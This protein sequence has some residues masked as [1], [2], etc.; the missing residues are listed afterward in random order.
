MKEGKAFWKGKL[1]G[2]YAGLTNTADKII[3]E[4]PDINKYKLYVEPF[5]GKGRTARFIDIPMILNDRSEYSVW[6]CK[7]EF[8]NASVS[9]MDFMDTIDKYDDHDVFFLLDP[10]WRKKHYKESDMSFCDR[11]V[12]DYYKQLLDRVETMKGDWFLCGSADEHESNNIIRKS[13][14]GLKIVSSDKKVIFGKKAQTMICSNLFDPNIK[15]KYYSAYNHIIPEKK[16]NELMCKVC[17]F[18]ANDKKT[19]NEHL[20]R[21]FHIEQCD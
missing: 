13:R 10:V 3:A 11:G 14:W 9:N 4:I 17:G 8:P 1:L 16:T 19:F 15:E 12:M 20:S 6:Y 2:G 7:K 21:R 5:C 18:G